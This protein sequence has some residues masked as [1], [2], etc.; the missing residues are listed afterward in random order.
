MEFSFENQLYAVVSKDVDLEEDSEI[1]LVKVDLLDGDKILRNIESD[2]EYSRV[3]KELN[4]L[5]ISCTNEIYV[6]SIEPKFFTDFFDN[7][8]KL[9]FLRTSKLTKKV[10]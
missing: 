3:E 5:N 10:R 7:C 6:D 1:Y 8:D 4:G 9:A 2:V